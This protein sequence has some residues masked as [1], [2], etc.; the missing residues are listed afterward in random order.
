MLIEWTY[1]AFQQT[2][3]YFGVTHVWTYSTGTSAVVVVDGN[4]R[5]LRRRRR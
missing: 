1:G 3:R 2:R 5:G 4:S